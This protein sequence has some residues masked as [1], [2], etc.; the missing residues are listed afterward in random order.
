MASQQETGISEEPAREFSPKRRSR[1]PAW[2]WFAGV[3]LLYLVLALGYSIATPAF[4]GPDEP[5][6]FEYVRS[7]AAH[8]EL[9]RF[10]LMRNDFSAR[11]EVVH[12][13]L[14]GPVYYAL[15]VP[16]YWLFHSGGDIATL[17]V[18]RAATAGLGVVLLWL[19]YATT[20][21][22]FQDPFIARGAALATACHPLVPYLGSVVSNETLAAVWGAATLYFVARARTGEQ[23]LRPWILAGVAYGL[24]LATKYTA[25][26]VLGP[27]L[28]LLF[29]SWRR[30]EAA[31]PLLVR[32]LGAFS[33]AAVLISG[34]WFLRN[35]LMYGRPVVLQYDMPLFPGGPMQALGLYEDAVAGMG[36][37]FVRF[38]WTLIGPVWLFW[39]Y[40]DLFERLWPA[41]ALFYLFPVAGWISRR[42]RHREPSPVLEREF[43]LGVL[44]MVLLNVGGVVETV[45]FKQELM[46][47]FAGRFL[48]VSMPWL[49]LLAVLGA[50]GW[51]RLPERRVWPVGA[52]CAVLLLLN[53]ALIPAVWRLYR[54]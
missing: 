49:V 5:E 4:H 51:V 14:H 16:L 22:V 35:L 48:L 19:V 11:P 26:V 21:R 34:G 46:T 3:A 8:G 9:P 37:L 23:G 31:V 43:Q 18:M 40:L 25:G 30:K 42:R 13:G 17:L 27:V 50:A 15:M 33:V 32:R 2:S 20:A 45:F 41:L 24:G 38:Y 36:Y 6:H 7:L 54:P 53:T 10:D 28:L 29:F 1:W 47:I 39:K 44:L 52:F 12:T